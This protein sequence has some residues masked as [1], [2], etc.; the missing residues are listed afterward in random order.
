MSDID[1]QSSK[2]TSSETMEIDSQHKEMQK[3][4]EEPELIS[5]LIQ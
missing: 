3:D 1:M 4:E 5:I 2:A